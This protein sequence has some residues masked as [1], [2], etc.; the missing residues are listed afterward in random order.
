MILRI[1]G[2]NIPVNT[3]S[4]AVLGASLTPDPWCRNRD[5]PDEMDFGVAR[6][7][8]GLDGLQDLVLIV[9]PAVVGHAK[10]FGFRVVTP[11]TLQE[12]R[13]ALDELAVV[14]VGLAGIIVYSQV[15][16]DRVR[17]QP[18]KSH[19]ESGRLKSRCP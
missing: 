4:L 2:S 13:I 9:G 12:R 16:D 8:P 18:L 19:F 5:N 15:D 3:R 10:N 6:R 14:R 17:V 11:D 7:G 1:T